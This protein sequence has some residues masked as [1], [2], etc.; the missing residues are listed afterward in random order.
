MHLASAAF[1]ILTII[2]S[3]YLT[4]SL[5]T[6]NEEDIEPDQYEE[7]FCNIDAICNSKANN[8]ISNSDLNNIKQYDEFCSF[9]IDKYLMNDKD[10]GYQH[11]FFNI[12]HNTYLLAISIGA[13][14]NN[15]D[16]LKIGII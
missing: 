6:Q 1:I 2:N 9:S 4:H 13:F 12:T 11:F 15:N 3:I 16:L 10:K 14:L 7:P 5:Y 8:G